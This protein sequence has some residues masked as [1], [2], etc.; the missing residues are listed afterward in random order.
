MLKKRAEG[1]MEEKQGELLSPATSP[2]SSD[3]TGALTLLPTR[4]SQSHT[5]SHL[6]APRDVP[7]PKGESRRGS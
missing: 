4:V 2:G 6:D 1:F 7:S 3:R 5:K